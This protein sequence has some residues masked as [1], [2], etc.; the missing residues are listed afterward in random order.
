MEIVIDLNIVGE[1]IL[2]SW[3]PVQHSTRSASETF[4]QAEISFIAVGRR[5]A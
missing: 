2:F 4:S 5:E 1:I 3:R